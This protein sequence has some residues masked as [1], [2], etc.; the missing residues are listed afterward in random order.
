LGCNIWRYEA[1]PTQSYQVN[2][3]LITSPDKNFYY[4][5]TTNI[6]D[7]IIYFYKIEFVFPD[8]TLWHD[9]ATSSFKNIELNIVGPTTVELVA[10]PKKQG[11][12]MINVYWGYSS[13]FTLAYSL[14]I[15]D[16]LITEMNPYELEG[17]TNYILFSFSDFTE[18][19]G[20]ILTSVCHLKEL[21][22]TQTP[23]NKVPELTISN[24]PNPFTEITFLNA[25]IGIGDIYEMSIFDSKGHVIR[26]LENR[27]LH[28][29]NYT[30]SWDRK[31]ENGIRV[32]HG[33]YYC[34]VNSG[35]SKNA[36]KLL[37]Q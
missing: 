3:E 25:K 34:I 37:V 8:D 6:V 12:F 28:P 30:Y 2:Q 23:E 7:T 11:N 20:T 17:S 32:P 24:Y 19:C 21:L 16:S 36:L 14:F 27:F 29:G 15:E 1:G 9:M 26:I 35:K 10:Q 5:D 33:I 13:L 22:L 18:N 4:L 31:N